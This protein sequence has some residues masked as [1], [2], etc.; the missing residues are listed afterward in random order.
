MSATTIVTSDGYRL[1]AQLDGQ[2]D[3]TCVLLVHGFPDDSTVWDGVTS[4]LE[5]DHFV[6]RLDTRGSGLSDRPRRVGDYRMSRLVADVEEVITHIAPGRSVH[7]VG[8]DWGSVQAWRLINTTEL[9][10]ASFTSISGPCLD[11]VPRWA[12][13]RLHEGPRGWRKLLAM[14]KSPLYM[15]LFQIPVV[16]PMLCRVGLV[17]AVI[18]W[19]VRREGPPASDAPPR[20]GLA[21]VNHSA[22]KIYTANVVP[23]LLRARRCATNVPVQVIAPRGDLFIPAVTQVDIDPAV[24]TARVEIVEGGHWT[25]QRTPRP[26]AELVAAWVSAHTAQKETR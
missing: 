15:T 7:V 4:E 11:H 20:R 10:I 2:P 8:H 12:W 17:D 26:I 6:V 23:G 18:A 22:L 25:P 5:S 1:S 16:A 3:A 9:P 19:S 14:W 13:D 21:R 24:R